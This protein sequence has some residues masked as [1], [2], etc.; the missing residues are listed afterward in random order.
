MLLSPVMV[1]LYLVSQVIIQR[2]F[3]VGWITPRIRFKRN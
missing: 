1:V 3:G 2:E